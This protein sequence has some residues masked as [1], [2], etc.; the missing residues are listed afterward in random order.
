MPFG[1][2][3]SAQ[4]PDFPTA[5]G[6]LQVSTGTIEE[7]VYARQLYKQQQS[8]SAIEGTDEKRHFAGLLVTLSLQ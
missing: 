8:R 3:F 6:L 7:V 5:L 1:W 2:E 4:Q